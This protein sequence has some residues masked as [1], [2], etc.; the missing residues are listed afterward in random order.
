MQTQI[1][2]GSM[3]LHET[4][5]KDAMVSAIAETMESAEAT[6]ISVVI[7][8]YN[9]ESLVGQTIQNMLDQ[10]LPP[11]EIIVVDD[12]STDGSVEVI[13]SFGDRVRL[14][15][16]GNCGP[17]A[18]RNAGLHAATGK[19]VQFMD[20]DDLASR[21]KLEA[22]AAVLERT[23]AD[24]V[25]SPWAKV[26]LEDNR[27]VFQDHVLQ[28][29]MPSGRLPIVCWWL[30]G[31]STVFQSL[32]MRRSFLDRSG[33]YRTDLMLGE[34]SEFFL[35]LLLNQPKIA[36][37][38][39]CLTLYRLHALNKLTQ[40]EGCAAARRIL[41]WARYLDLAAASLAASPARI[42]WRTRYWFAA[43]ARKHLAALEAI[44]EAPENSK[45]RL[46][47]QATA[48]PGWLIAAGLFWD[49]ACTRARLALRGSRWS[50]AYRSG[51][52]TPE[53]R[54]LIEEL[55]YAAYG[56]AG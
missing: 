53:Q 45:T 27:A 16:Q 50:A 41:D 38:A 20:S 32:L 23:G 6:H 1:P 10:S 43:G 7:P 34:D 31:W 37:T 42:D 56:D 21:N 29:A 18:A 44:P 9:R 4:P 11:H 40:D 17:G 25:F 52:P 28:Q 5:S 33:E 8:N 12:G 55:G 48:F 26:T 30:R 54:R 15:E 2:I 13:R 36:F 22:Q 51:P 39:E 14:I 24:I 47:K 19:Y 35:R 3:W 46:R 49:R